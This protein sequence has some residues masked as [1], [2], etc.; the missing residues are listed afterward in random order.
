M[1]VKT[2][3]MQ[4]VK[5]TLECDDCEVEMRFDNFALTSDPPIFPHTC[6]NCGRKHNSSFITGTV[7]HEALPP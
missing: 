7:M 1:T 2:T 6:P 3:P 5:V 4:A